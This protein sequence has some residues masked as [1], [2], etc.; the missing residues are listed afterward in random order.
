[1]PWNAHTP[2]SL[3]LD[4]VRLAEH[5][6]SFAALCRRFGISRK[7]GYKW[8]ERYRTGGEAALGDRSR[9]PHRSPGRTP[10]EVEAAVLRIR[11][12][13]PAW[14]GRKIRAVL[15]REPDIAERVPA[16]ATVTAVLRRHGRLSAEPA[17]RPAAVGRFEAEA[18]NELW[19]MDFKGD[20]VLGDGARCY[21]LTLLD[22]HSRFSLCLAACADQRRS[23]VQTHLVALFR[24]YGLPRR[25]LCDNGPPWGSACP[26]PGGERYARGRRYT[27][28]AVWLIRLGV[29]V[30][31]GRPAHPQTQGKEE[32]FHRT[33]SEEVLARG[34][35]ADRP[36]CQGR[37]DHWRALYNTYRPHEAIELAVPASRYRAS[38]RPYPER[39]PSVEYAAS[40]VVRAVDVQGRLSFRGTV[41]RVG[42]GLAG[43]RVALREGEPDGEWSVY[44]CHQRVGRLDL[45]YP[46]AEPDVHL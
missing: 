10:P 38:E 11:D 44:L 39:L 32:R 41:F 25:V 46:D 31:H 42:K 7:T 14:G 37:F 1:M 35:P 33:L 2:M 19:Q 18:P 34:I 43:Q 28:L 26:L 40:D 36:G 27:R 12:A 15:L 9:A 23:T 5:T 45:R 24:E 17:P 16:P 29:T 30:V 4:F 20:F 13:H 22:D 6:P 3:R 21:P 8:V